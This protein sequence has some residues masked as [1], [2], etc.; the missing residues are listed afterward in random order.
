LESL[1][2]ART[3][4]DPRTIIDSGRLAEPFWY[5]D[6]P[7]TTPS[8]PVDGFPAEPGAVRP[9]LPGVLCPDGPCVVSGRPT[10]LRRLFGTGF[11]VL[12]ARRHEMNLRTDLPH[13][14]HALD[15][16]DGDGVLREALQA[17]PDTVH[18]VRP[19]GP[20]AA[21]RPPPAPH[22]VASALHRAAGRWPA[23]RTAR[24]ALCPGIPLTPPPRRAPAP[25][26]STR[27]WA[28]STP[29]R[30]ASAGSSANGHDRSRW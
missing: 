30:P 29:Q 13:E 4:P 20:L 9:P 19:D 23:S 6:S 22:R 15:D 5:L 27:G 26:S 24:A 14:I 21:V 12:T 8:R 3:H 1:E 28:V 7:L 17:G 25:H 11:V 16:I 10:R 18:V 2:R